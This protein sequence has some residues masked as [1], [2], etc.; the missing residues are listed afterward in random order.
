V[1]RREEGRGEGI[2]SMNLQASRLEAAGHLQAGQLPASQLP[3]KSKVPL[4]YD[5]LVIPTL[6]DKPQQEPTPKDESALKPL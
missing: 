4:D 3:N 6:R 5:S 1:V 2:Q